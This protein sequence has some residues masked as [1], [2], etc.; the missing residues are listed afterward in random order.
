VSFGHYEDMGWC[1]WVDV[2]KGDDLIILIEDIAGDFS[3]YDA[4]E[5]TVCIHHFYLIP[6]TALA[7]PTS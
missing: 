4:A 1:L 5:D 7:K 6:W 3:D 2:A